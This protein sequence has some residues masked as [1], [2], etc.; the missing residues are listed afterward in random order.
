MITELYKNGFEE[1]ENV[2]QIKITLAQAELSLLQTKKTQENQLN[3]LK[4]VLGIDLED[5]IILTTS[6]NNFIG[7]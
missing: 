2:E 6:I 1:I 4:L 3:L 7:E 5:E